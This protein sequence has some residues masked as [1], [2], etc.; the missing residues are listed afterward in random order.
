MQLSQFIGD[1]NSFHLPMAWNGEPFEP[2]AQ[3]SLIW[4]VKRSASEDDSS[5][6]IQK[7][8]GAGIAVSGS[9]AII[10]VVPS[11]TLPIPAVQLVWDLQAQNLTTG[12]VR[13]VAFGGLKLVRDVTR[14][15][16]TSLPVYTNQPG[17]PAAGKSAYEIAVDNGFAGN[18]S[19][20]LTSLTGAKGETELMKLDDVSIDPET[21]DNESILSYQDWTQTWV[22]SYKISESPYNGATV[23]RRDDEGR[24]S[25]TMLRLTNGTVFY[26]QINASPGMM[27]QSRS[28]TLPNAS[29][30]FLLDTTIGNSVVKTSDD[31]TIAGKKTF[32]GQVELMNQKAEN[33]AS[34]MNLH[35]ADARYGQIF[36]SLSTSLLQSF[37]TTPIVVAS[38]SLPIGTYQFDA[39]L[40]EYA[41]NSPANCTVTLSANLPIKCGL[42]E[43]Y[44]GSSVTSTVVS[45][46]NIEST[47]R[48]S[49]G[50]ATEFRRS[51]TGIVEVFN[52]N[53]TLSLSFNQKDHDP[54]NP[55]YCRKRAYIIARKIA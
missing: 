40:A 36:K 9:T 10:E 7:I 11:D 55:S 49:T 28:Y 53:T 20:W 22:N 35:L 13:T 41:E 50:T 4:T 23:V 43:F 31:Q 51:L 12:E 21:L 18:E 45:G 14:K 29:G 52:L 25:A 38:V 37:D 8:S 17:A 54:I 42:S 16:T 44:G 3:W 48:S 26:G 47:S 2:A 1:S 34:V 15:T 5:A 19:Q 46:D 39:F 27:S 6:V 24:I 32:T 33:G 30:T